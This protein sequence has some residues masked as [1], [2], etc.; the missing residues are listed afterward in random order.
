[1][2]AQTQPAPGTPDKP[3]VL[4]GGIAMTEVTILLP[5]YNRARLLVG[6][7][8]SVIYQSFTDWE[9]IVLDDCSTDSTGAIC[10]EFK[11]KDC[12]IKYIRNDRNL[13]TPK[14]RNVG[15]SLAKGNWILFIEDDTLLDKNCLKELVTNKV[16]GK[17]MPCLIT[18]G[19]CNLNKPFTFNK[20]T[21]EVLNAH[22]CCLYPKSA[23]DKVGG[24]SGKF[25]GNY[26]REETDLDCRLKRAGYKFNYVPSAIIYHNPAE[27][28]SWK[29]IPHAKQ[30]YYT[31]RNHLVYLSRNFGWRLIYMIPFYAM[32]VIKQSIIMRVQNEN[33]ICLT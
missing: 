13:G 2:P 25:I 18:N 3:I 28:G 16:G 10:Q 23:L 30:V 21:G 22:A 6:C 5:T 15:I 27:H 32:S 20:W 9:L 11:D 12:R 4:E 26:Y 1:M 29:D 33:P 14:N 24:Y 31:H 8:R 17:N 19:K 7:I